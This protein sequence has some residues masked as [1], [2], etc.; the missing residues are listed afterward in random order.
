M[1]HEEHE[2]HDGGMAARG[3]TRPMALSEIR[4]QQSDSGHEH[5]GHDRSAMLR[6]H[7]KQTLWVYWFL[8]MLGVWLVLNPLT[9]G[10]TQGTVEPSGGRGVWL[11]LGERAAA[12]QWSDIL[13]GLLL[14]LFGWR[15]L[16]PNR[17][18]SLWICCFVGIWLTMAPVVF[19]SPTAAG[20]LNGSLVGMLVIGL[21]IMI[22]GM[23]NMIMFMAHGT[24]VPKGW[25]Y[26]PSSW[27]Q[28]WI[29]IAVGFVGYFVSRYLAAFQLGY[30]DFVWDP[31]FGDQ[32]R[33][34][35]NSEM[36]HSFPISDAAMGTAAYT[37]EFL[38][39]FMGSPQRWRTM[40][41]MVFVFGILVIPLGLVHIFLVISQP[42]VVGHWCTFCL[43]AAAVMLPMI[44][45]E[46]DE[47][48]AMGQFMVQAKRK[49]LNLWK[50]F[51]LGGDVEGE[52]DDDRSP[53]LASLPEQPGKVFAS[54]IW[55]MSFPWT[56]VVS[57]LLGIGLMFV[58]QCLVGRAV[59][60]RR[61]K[62][63]A[64]SS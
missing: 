30:I 58:P 23:P 6:M 31:F 17:P 57:A 37:F 39:G 20:F 14:I 45:L 12:M 54:S 25:S 56:L 16:R 32:T 28:R 1:N 55:G 10:Y 29:M 35:L 7:H 27:P 38:M 21:T 26:N 44:P 63:A 8:I 22:P 53:A 51:W 18:I 5:G 24:T 60:P 11:T 34:V 50:A 36:S 59:S 42:V 40:P 3:V 46:V 62:L 64:L 2:H 49:Q 41:W 13:S 15:S 9:F 61:T 4:D 33:L 47:V 52:G 19:W 48:V 43:L